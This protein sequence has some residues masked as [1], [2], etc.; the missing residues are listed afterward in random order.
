MRQ[1]VCNKPNRYKIKTP[2]AY[3]NTVPNKRFQSLA[4]IRLQNSS[5]L[6]LGGEIAGS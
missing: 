5:P 4:T 3:K 6:A 1:Q 2:V